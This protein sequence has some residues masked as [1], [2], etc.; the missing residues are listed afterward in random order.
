MERHKKKLIMN[1]TVAIVQARMS[2]RRLPGKMLLKLSKISILEWVLK[3]VKKSREINNIILA[4][5]TNR[6]DDVLVKIAKKN[7]VSIFRGS[8]K[9]VLGR[10]FKAASKIKANNVVRICA[11]NPFVDPEE[12]DLLVSTFKSNNFDYV[13]NHQNRMNNKYADGFGAEIL[14]YNVLRKLNKEVASPKHREHVTQ[15]MW[16]KIKNFKIFCIPA[17]NDL[18]FPKLRF[19]IDTKKDLLNL[20]KL[21]KKNKIN[22]KT[23]AKE[24]IKYRLQ[25]QWN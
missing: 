17:S 16:K 7:K 21:V 4:T 12:L 2:S 20:K 18:A 13:C 1:N 14:S 19:D 24:I 15:F 8:N 25:K 6:E 9:D 5:T 3:R 10:I 22:L 11:D 23:K